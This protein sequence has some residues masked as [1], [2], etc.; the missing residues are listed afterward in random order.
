MKRASPHQWK[1]EAARQLRDPFDTSEGPLIRVLLLL[2]DERSDL[3]VT[4]HHAI[5]DG[6]SVSCLMRDLLE[7]ANGGEIDSL[8][9]PASQH[10]RL[11]SRAHSGN[12]D[13]H[14]GEEASAPVLPKQFAFRPHVPAG[15][16][17]DNV[18]LSRAE[19][20]CLMSKAREESTTIHAVVLASLVLAGRELS[21]SWAENP[22]EGFTPI[23]L[24]K[25]LG[26]EV[27]CVVALS[28]GGTLLDPE[29]NANL[30]DIARD[31][32]EQL[33]PQETMRGIEQTLAYFDFAT[34]GK[35]NS[36]SVAEAAS[37]AIGFKLM[38][39]NLGNLSYE[40]EIPGLTLDAL[41]GPVI[42]LG[43]ENEQTVSAATI[44]G[45]LMLTHTSLSPI[46]GLLER[47]AALLIA[48]S[49]I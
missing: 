18:R 10:E 17:I 1:D 7:A 36:A 47:S 46:R 43:Y 41:W 32:K 5:A 45:H 25:R 28:A 49:Y 35:A 37:K 26:I 15:A 27:D 9:L 11:A 40:T 12:L 21:T 38:L 16:S 39:T 48:A 13:S 44:H 2:D 8:P 33:R 42:S 23:S 34:A 22:V 14:V 3:V 24:R 29:P 30:W 19:T 20:T 4:V 31:A 6:L